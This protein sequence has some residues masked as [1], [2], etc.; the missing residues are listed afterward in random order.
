M[1]SYGT[2]TGKNA[3]TARDFYGLSNSNRQEQAQHFS[4]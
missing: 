3:L 4:G 1:E 2:T